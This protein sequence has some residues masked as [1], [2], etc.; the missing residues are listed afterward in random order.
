MT[1]VEDNPTVQESSPAP[2]TTV[3]ETKQEKKHG[4]KHE[5]AKQR[6]THHA[7]SEATIREELRQAGHR[8]VSRASRTITPS[9]ANKAVRQSSH[10]YVAHYIHIDPAHY[11]TDMR[12][13]SK[14]GQYVGFI[15][16]TEQTYQCH[17]KTKKEALQA[18][19]SPA[20]SRRLNEMIHY[21]GTAWR[22]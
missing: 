17:G 4:K 7:K 20:S 13:A 22:D 10:G 1:A 6:T 11:S 8:L 9:K 2:T 18:P 5:K 16:Y 21:D 14:P 19:C 15:R 12:P 3:A